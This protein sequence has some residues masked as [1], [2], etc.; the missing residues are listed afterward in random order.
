VQVEGT[1]F[2]GLRP[3][4]GFLV[5][6]VILEVFSKVQFLFQAVLLVVIILLVDVKMEVVRPFK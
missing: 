6:V 2:M 3:V 5:R 4:I 1:D